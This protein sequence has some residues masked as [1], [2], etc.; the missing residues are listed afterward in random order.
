[1][2]RVNVALKKFAALSLLAFA[3]LDDRD[4]TDCT[5]EAV[6][7]HYSKVVREKYEPMAIAT[8]AYYS[9]SSLS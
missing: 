3:G 9:P 2:Y 7:D 4:G 6:Y 1:M 8:T 5:A